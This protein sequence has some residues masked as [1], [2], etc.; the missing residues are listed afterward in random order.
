MGPT[1]NDKCPYN[2]H[3]VTQRREDYEE[4]DWSR[5]WSDAAT[6]KMEPP[7]AR[8]AQETCSPAALPMPPFSLL[9]SGL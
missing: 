1:P 5:D 3:T 7:A 9:G 4:K 2:R 8:E 6:A